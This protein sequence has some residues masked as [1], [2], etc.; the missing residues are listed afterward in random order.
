MN[1]KRHNLL[2]FL[3]NVHKKVESTFLICFDKIWR[4]VFYLQS[5]Y[6]SPF[7][8]KYDMFLIFNLELKGQYQQVLSFPIRINT[9]S[10]KR[11]K[12]SFD[13][14]KNVSK[15]NFLNYPFLLEKR[16]QGTLKGLSKLNVFLRSQVVRKKE[17]GEREPHKFWIHC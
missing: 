12:T 10:K 15:K 2:Y 11:E 17:R 13:F 6:L 9:M 8:Y 16:G 7:S 4:N 5:V 14:W 1:T 3:K